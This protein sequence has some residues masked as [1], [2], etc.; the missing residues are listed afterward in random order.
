MKKIYRCT[1]YIPAKWKYKFHTYD[2]RNDFVKIF[3]YK[4]LLLFYD[5]ISVISTPFILIFYLPDNS[6]EIVEFI[7]MNTLDVKNVGNVCRYAY[8]EDFNK[9]LC[10]DKKIKDSSITLFEENH[11]IDKKYDSDESDTFEYEPEIKN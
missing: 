10:L 6:I 8:F 11:E 5:L 4:I 1:K 3:P 2:V 9:N 7:K